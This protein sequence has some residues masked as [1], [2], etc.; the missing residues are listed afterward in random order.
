MTPGDRFLDIGCGW[1][2]MVCWAARNYG[3][4]AHGITLS[5]A[6]L[7]VAKDRIRK[8]GLSG[9][10]TVEKRDYRDLEGVGVF[11][12]VS[13]IGMFEH[14]GLKSL[15]AYNETVY[16][17][18][19]ENGLFLNHGITHAAD[20]WD[21]GLNSKF[22]QKYVFPDG[23]LDRVSNIGNGMESAG[24]EIIDVEN[25]RFHYARTLREWVKRLE[26]N[27]RA[28]QGFVGEQRYKIWRMYMAGSALEF[29][30]GKTGIHQI[31]G[32]KW[33]RSQG[34]VPATRK[35]MYEGK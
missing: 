17:V 16:R 21:T 32:A 1:G 4:K 6:Q 12:K 2:A 19:S 27:R 26:G 5:D 24:F 13:S 22:L 3:V 14:V 7:E 20:G 15:E 10:V 34:L 25:L 31:L 9:L 23:E 30:E 29:E 18:L 33:E 8:Q 11:D 35:Y 28:A